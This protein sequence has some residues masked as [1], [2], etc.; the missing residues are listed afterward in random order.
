MERNGLAM[1]TKAK[2]AQQTAE[3][4][5]EIAEFLRFALNVRKKNKY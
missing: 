2:A 5:I 4:E 1:R 3:Y